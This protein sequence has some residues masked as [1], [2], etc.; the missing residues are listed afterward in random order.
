MRYV[1]IPGVQSRP[2]LSVAAQ[3]EGRGG[4]RPLE[5][6]SAPGGG[7]L[8]SEPVRRGLQR[9]R[10]SVVG[11]GANV[12]SVAVCVGGGDDECTRLEQRIR[13]DLGLRYQIGRTS[14]R[15]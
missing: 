7:A 3:R 4:G 10:R 15:E 9:R 14:C 5:F 11:A 6:F 2:S 8:R 12:E 13:E 1:T